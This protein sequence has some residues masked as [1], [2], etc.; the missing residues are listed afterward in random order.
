MRQPKQNHCNKLI[1]ENHKHE[2]SKCKEWKSPDCF[3]KRGIGLTPCTDLQS[4]CKDCY[5]AIIKERYETDQN[6]KTV[7]VERAIKSSQKNRRTHYLTNQFGITESDYEFLLAQQEGKCALCRRPPSGRKLAIDHNHSHHSEKHQACNE[8]IRGLLCSGCNRYFVPSVEYN[9]NL[10]NRSELAF[11][12]EYL[13]GRPLS[14]Q[15]SMA[16]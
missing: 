4:R 13:N 3:Y 7:R 16:A 15:K 6:F 1:G 5:G 2:C 10:F 9:S 8:C 11:V 12:R 14:E